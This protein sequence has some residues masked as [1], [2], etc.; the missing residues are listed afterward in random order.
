MLAG[1]QN[2]SY[3]QCISKCMGPPE[4]FGTCSCSF[5]WEACEWCRPTAILSIAREPMHTVYISD[6]EG[7]MP[8]SLGKNDW[9]FSSQCWP[10]W[11]LTPFSRWVCWSL[12]KANRWTDKLPC[13]S[14]Q[15]VGARRCWDEQRQ[16]E[17]C[18]RL[19]AWLLLDTESVTFHESV[20]TGARRMLQEMPTWA[21][22]CFMM[23]NHGASIFMCDF[24]LII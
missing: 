12:W 11:I 7:A 10:Q 4:V 22:Q 9:C 5:K 14:L 15:A 8:H 19:L 21:F 24:Y 20:A 2:P 1:M 16:K 13:L 18:F 3:E 17:T 6:F 23:Y